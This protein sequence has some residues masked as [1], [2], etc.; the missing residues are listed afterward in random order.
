MMSPTSSRGSKSYYANGG[1]RIMEMLQKGENPQ[2]M[3]AQQYAA[4]DAAIVRHA[5]VPGIPHISHATPVSM[6][7]IAQSS[8]NNRILTV[9]NIP[10]DMPPMDL[11]TLF[12]RFGNVEGSYI[13]PHPDPFGRRFGQIAMATP[14]DAQKVGEL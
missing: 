13:F 12:K 9:A 7:Q 6:E 4:P 8:L 3:A 10:A 5:P 11:Y 1:A 2:Q 14:Y